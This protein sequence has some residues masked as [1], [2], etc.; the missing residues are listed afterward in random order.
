LPKGLK[1]LKTK[2]LNLNL[3][4]CYFDEIKA[5]TKDEEYRLVTPYWIKR[6]ENRDYKGIVI[7]KG[8][9]KNDDLSRIITRPWRAY[10]IKTITHPHFG[11][12]PVKVFAIKVN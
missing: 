2:I 6:L 9:P 3:K 7:K 8:Y 12:E 10:T 5:G 1:S 11:S 4:G